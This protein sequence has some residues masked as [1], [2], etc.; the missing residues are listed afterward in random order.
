MILNLEIGGNIL[1]RCV[2]ILYVMLSLADWS[3]MQSYR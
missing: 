2:C 3:L 1:E